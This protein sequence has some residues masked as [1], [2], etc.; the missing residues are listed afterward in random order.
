[1]DEY[2]INVGLLNVH[3]KGLRKPCGVLLRPATIGDAIAILT[4]QTN[5]SIAKIL[6][7]FLCRAYLIGC[8]TAINLIE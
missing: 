8:V 4:S 3:S 1:M 2:I 5:A 6:F 7:E